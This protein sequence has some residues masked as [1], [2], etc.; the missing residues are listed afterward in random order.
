MRCTLGV[1]VSGAV[2]V[3]PD[4]FADAIAVLPQQV[5]VLLEMGLGFWVCPRRRH[6]TRPARWAACLPVPETRPLGERWAA[7]TQLI[8][9]AA[10]GI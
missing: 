2:Y 4:D 1:D 10:S 9:R 8:C 3:R 6:R 7:T 5:V